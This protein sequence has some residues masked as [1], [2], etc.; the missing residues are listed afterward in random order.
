MNSLT[1][2][3]QRH[4]LKIFFFG[5]LLLQIIQ[6]SSTELLDDEAYYWVYSKFPEW[7]YF[8][9]PPMIAIL[10]KA[11]TFLFPG[12]LGVRFFIV[13]LNTLTL[14]I[15]YRLLERKNDGLFYLIACSMAVLQIGGFLAVP[16]IPLTFF[17]ALFFL[18]YKNFL[19]DSSYLNSLLLGI[20]AALLLYSKYHGIL[21]IF[22]TVLSK[23]RLLLSSKAWF[24]WVICM[25]FYL[26]HLYWQYIHDFPSI[27]FHLLERAA[28]KYHFKYT[29]SY[30]GDQI[31]L[32]GPLT[33]WLI[34]WAAF[35][36]RATNQFEKTLKYS[37]IGI[38][39][40]FFVS[41]FRGRV[42]AN[43]TMS[44]F[45]PLL[46][47]SHQYLITQNKLVRI[48]RVMLP[49]TLSLVMLARVYMMLD[50]PKNNII[51]KDE[52][53]AN[54]EWASIIK[55][56]AKDNPVVFVNTYQLA[57]KYWFYSGDTSLSLNGILYRRSNYNFWPLDNITT[58]KSALV[59]SP[60]DYKYYR[61]TLY[62]PLGKTGTTV[63]RPF[64]CFPRVKLF[65]KNP[66]VVKNGKLQQ[67]FLCVEIDTGSLQQI[68]Q[69]NLKN[70][71]VRMYFLQNDRKTAV[72]FT[73]I[74]LKDLQ[75][76][77]EFDISGLPVNLKNG[78]YEVKL[79]LPSSAI[80]DPTL[81]SS[82][83]DAKVE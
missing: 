19:H 28:N 73:N 34:I 2:F 56:R 41:T 32:A 53:H 31:L 17:A 45:I 38:Y 71:H 23:P 4:H 59:V 75:H 43:W 49:V 27:Q 35:K 36:F 76:K 82:S 74:L 1:L 51:P 83:I 30:I 77:K 55:Q 46:I 48:L 39:I 54:N 21:I 37:M 81:N 14:Y 63:I 22:F 13:I 80:F 29:L 6:A 52:I 79:S 8:D 9:H 12:E 7:G 62:T 5:W 26:P 60:Y 3:I 70:M 10:I 58:A 40:F 47:L 15:I 24:A 16:D 33:G 20:I 64:F 18:L 42:E 50:L 61:D 72:V 11:G 68:L 57:S 78:N 69:S 65:L 66:L 25:L 67:N 44:A